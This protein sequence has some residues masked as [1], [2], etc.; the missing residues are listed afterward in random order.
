MW[1]MKEFAEAAGATVDEL[2]A[3]VDDSQHGVP[4]VLRRRPPRELAD[5]LGLARWIREG[6]MTPE[7]YRHFLRDYLDE[8]TRLHHPAYLGHQT[9]AP[10]FPAALADFVHGAINNPMAIYEMG[11]S[12]A[13]V[14]F[15]VLRWML[16]TVGFGET[17]GGVLTHGG[18]LAN[19]TALLAAR[20]HVAPDAWTDG[21]PGDLVLLAP[22]S[23][24]YS[25]TRAAAILGM[26][27]KAVL[28][29]D[30]DG[31]GRIDVAALPAALDRARRLG[32]RV[33]AVVAGACATSSGLY[34]DLRGIGEV[35]ARHGV[36]LHVDGAHGA[37]ALLSERHR[38]LLDGIELADSVIWDAHKMLRTAGL[39]AAV[40]TRRESDLDAAFRQQASYLFYGDQGFDLVGRTV[41][42]TKAGLGLKI[43]LNLAWLGEKGMGDFVARQYDT[44]HRFWELGRDRPG[45]DFPYEPETN[46]VCFRYGTADQAAVRERL[47]DDGSFHL[48][49]AEIGG[50]RHLRVTVMAPATDDTTL[51]ALLTKIAEA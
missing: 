40:L 46:I 4:P 44:A 7:A 47:M 20:A 35:C 14:E 31:L 50:V 42:C 43:F 24:H 18:S 30:V 16:A 28:P 48:T 37:S 49:S 39:A 5:K 26:G 19:L 29:L 36:W 32:R 38:H 10:Y 2:G 9:A 15:E 23:A 12:A 22:P 27:E 8:G 6:G 45:F 3:Y 25:V 13:T 17:G 41:E 33:M 11:A 21:V 1:D 51:E 34:D